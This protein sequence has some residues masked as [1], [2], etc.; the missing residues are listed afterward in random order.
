MKRFWKIAA[1]CCLLILPAAAV[2][3]GDDTTLTLPAG[4]EVIEE[5]AFYGVASA[6]KAVVPEGTVS[7]GARAFAE[8]GFSEIRLPSTVTE[9][10]AGAFQNCGKAEAAQRYYCIP[11]GVTV[12]AGAFDGCR[13]D[14]YINGSLI[15]YLSYSIQENSVTITGL[16]GYGQIKEAVIPDTIE[17]KPVTSIANDVFYNRNTVTRI[18]I[19][20]TVTEIGNN[21][22][23]GCSSLTEID[24]PAAL[25]SIGSS[26]FRSCTSLTGVELPSGV[27]FIGNN[28]FRECSSLTEIEIPAGVTEIAYETFAGDRNLVRAVLP[29]GL[30]TI[31]DNAF[32]DCYTLAEIEI[33]SAVTSIGYQA[34]RYNEALT[35]VTIPSGITDLA[36][37]A[38]VNCKKLVSVHLPEGMV[39]IGQSTF[40]GCTKLSDVNFPAGLTTI[41]RKAFQNT[42]I[43]Q[44]GYPVYQL[45]DSLETVG[46]E[47]FSGCGAALCVTRNGNLESLIRE[48]GNTLTYYD[49]QDYR[50]QYKKVNDAYTLYL[51]GY[52]GAGGNI[53]IPAGPVVI[54]ENAFKQNTQV[55]GVT[56]PEGVTKIDW[57]AFEGCTGLT[58]LTMPNS[59][60]SIENRAF[61]SCTNL[62]NIVFS[63]AL[64]KIES[65][66]FGYACTA[67]GT[68]YY[69]LPDSV[70]EF[71]GSPFS[72]CGAVLCVKRGSSTEELVR[73]NAY[74]GNYTHYGETDFRYRYYGSEGLERLVQYVGTGNA[75][76]EIPPYVWMIDDNA[77]RDHTE[78]TGVTIPDTVTRINNNVFRDCANLTNISLPDSL[79]YIADSAFNGCGSNAADGFV[80]NLP[81]GITD[82]GS[83]V[84][85][86]SP[87]ILV[88]DKE[89]TTAAMISHRDWS[90]VRADRADEPDIR[91]KYAYFN[92]NSWEWAL[93]DYVGDAASVQLPDDCVNVISN[94]FREKPDLE[95][96]CSQLSDTAEGLSRAELNFTFPGHEGLRY[97]IIEGVLYIMGY[98]GTGNEIIIPQVTAYIQ[99]GNWDEQIRA[100]AFQGMENITKVVIPEGVTRINSDAFTNC[101]DLTDITFPDSLKFIEQNAFLWCGRDAQEDFYFTLPDYMEDMVGRGGGANTFSDCNAILRTGKESATAAL[102]TD[103]NYCYTVAGE[104]DFRYRY[105]AETVGEETVRRLWLAGYV[106]TDTTAAIPQG[107]YGIRR[108]ASDTTS[109]QWHTFYADGFY[110]N[111]TVTK[112]IIPEGTEVIDA[113]AFFGCLNLT[114]ITFPESLKVLR[115]HAFEQCGKNADYLH[116]YVLPDDMTEISTNTAA[117]WGAF[118][119]INKG[120]LVSSPGS[121]TALLLSGIDTVYHNGV[122]RFALKGHQTDGLLYLYRTYTTDE[123][124]VNRLILEQYEGTDAEVT[125]P[126]GCEIYSIADGVFQ[127]RSYLEKVVMPDG[128]ERIGSSAFDGCSMLH[129]GAEED[130]VIVPGT[131]K[132]AGN[133]AFKDLGSAYTAERFYLVLPSSLQEFDMNIFT[134]CNAVLVAPAGSAA[135]AALYNNWYRYYNTLEDARLQ[136]NMQMRI[137][138]EGQTV[139]YQGRG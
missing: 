74:D 20:S 44:P 36:D 111:E 81:S 18:T 49:R 120:R 138:E 78:L 79:T 15:P 115:D 129:D 19:P 58:S 14:V 125:I 9:I 41:G 134:G 21:A 46:T 35:Q 70:S 85:N 8:G 112:V 7:V 84:F 57:G 82:L 3:A 123:G 88:C 136:Q 29:Q 98:A 27:T 86:N 122:Y 127:D 37:S 99:D 11:N 65:D 72:N 128:I 80:L 12:G 119:D 132:S 34:F 106:G 107:I 51:T 17:G 13:A 42:C 92:N 40:E 118:T 117:G 52:A 131:V 126:S 66:A 26:A 30:T 67:E 54:G 95:L 64:T 110:G 10:G 43:N 113:W 56:I 59:V 39:S 105:M 32:N 55:T 93:Y 28:A 62:T 76:V 69:N 68:Y 96:V 102:L 124:T 139:Q 47:A 94:R 101:Y 91:Y 89:S 33:P 87:V 1:I 116:Y 97:R 22:F 16:Y 109:N 121:S 2:R 48:N 45:P 83:Y 71:R 114:D 73:G 137:P 75:S 103:R 5:E 63:N 25:T 38:F 100:R 60:L 23:R 53:T 61:Y 6:D 77:F 24:L 4:L 104:E 133:L 31:G 108:F 90:F 130:A 50:Y 135:A